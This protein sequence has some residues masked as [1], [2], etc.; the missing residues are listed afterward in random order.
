MHNTEAHWQE[1][2]LADVLTERTDTP[3]PMKIE[4]GTIPIVS[5]I[6]FSTGTIELRNDRKTRTKMIL[7]RAG[8]LLVSGIN[9]AK[10]A[11]A[12]H[13]ATRNAPIAAT[14]HYAAYCP[15]ESRADVRYLWYLLRSEAFRTI[16][17]RNLPGGVKTELKAH[18]LLPIKV[19]LPPLDEQRR[20]VARIEKLAA[21]IE[22]AQ[23]LRVKARE[24]TEAFTT[25]SVISVF[26]WNSSRTGWEPQPLRKAAE[27]KRG[28]F[29]HR[30]RNAPQ[31]YDGDIP[32]I[33]IGDISSSN[34]YIQQYSQTLNKDGLGIS[35]M[36]TSGTVVI[37]ITG[38]TIG[39]T[40]ILTF[41]SCFPDSIVGL[42]ARENVALPKF[43]YW[44]LEDVKREALAEA[45]Q[46]TQP[47]INLRILNKLMIPIPPLPEQQ[48][49]VDHLEYLQAQV[50]ELTALQE[51]TQAELEALLPSVLDRAFKGEL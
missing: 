45:T 37:A 22:V 19:P 13:D 29:A 5:K 36:F 34:R 50:D 17:K 10:G 2:R 27:I 12:L 4:D 41:D 11:I 39:A 1:V 15:D 16:L 35:R 44:A 46:T 33:Q 26:D 38:A 48:H 40:G 6:S 21:L 43:V 3:D 28:R 14:I 32:F 18:R 24:E 8:D 9:A 51:S 20:I 47:N 42:T 31:F 30:P 49:V 23:E 7:A 25:S